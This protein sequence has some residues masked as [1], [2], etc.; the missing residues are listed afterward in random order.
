MAKEVVAGKRISIRLACDIFQ[1]SE[2]CYRYS[3]KKSTP[4]MRKSPTGDAANRQPPRLGIRSVLSVPAQREGPW[5]ESQ[6]G[7]S[8]LPGVGTESADQ[9]QETAGAGETGTV[10]RAEGHQPGVVYGLHA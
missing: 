8:D 4:R 5:L 1:V 3:A 10:G 7:V 2:T 6:A 9:A